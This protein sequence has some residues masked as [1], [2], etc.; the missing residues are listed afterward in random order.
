MTSTLI[1]F[2]IILIIVNGLL[3]VSRRM[4]KKDE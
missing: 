1:T 2:V 3:L 4:D